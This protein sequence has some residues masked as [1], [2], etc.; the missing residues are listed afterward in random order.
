MQILSRSQELR[1]KTSITILAELM[2]IQ[3]ARIL[4]AMC[5]GNKC[6][7]L[8]VAKFRSTVSPKFQGRRSLIL[9][10]PLITSQLHVLQI[11]SSTYFHQP[12]YFETKYNR[13]A[14]F[15]N[16]SFQ[17]RFQ[18][19]LARSAKLAIYV[20]VSRVAALLFSGSASSFNDY[21]PLYR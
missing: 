13:S 5:L 1:R 4:L 8:S 9:L 18:G 7:Q 14:P 15:A 6:R 16:R 19:A 12:G 17:F 11:S 10:G 3:A 2:A 21:I 20:V